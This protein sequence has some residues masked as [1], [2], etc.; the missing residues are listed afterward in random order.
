MIINSITESIWN[1]IKDYIGNGNDNRSNGENNNQTGSNGSDQPNPYED[2]DESAEAWL[3]QIRENTDGLEENSDAADENSDRLDQNSR[4][5]RALAVASKIA[6]AAV[7]AL[8][9]A[10]IS[11]VVTKVVEF[12]YDLA[13]QEEIIAEK[14][15][16]AKQNI[17]DLNKTFNE[18]KK[19]VDSIASSYEELSKGV[20]SLTNK[21]ISLSTEDYEKYLE[22]NNKLVEIFPQL[23]NGIDENG[24]VIIRFGD[25]SQSATQQ[26]KE[27][28]A[29]Q[30]EYNSLKVREELPDLT[31]GAAQN[32]DNLTEYEETLE[33]AEQ[34]FN[35]F[36]DV[37]NAAQ[38]NDLSLVDNGLT[39]LSED[40]NT[41]DREL[42][43]ILEKSYMDFYSDLSK[44]E[45]KALINL[46]NPIENEVILGTD[47]DGFIT[48]GKR[49]KSIEGLTKK[50]RDE[51][52]AIIEE[53]LSKE[54]FYELFSEVQNNYNDALIEFNSEDSQVTADFN[55]VKNSL[56]QG[57]E[58]YY[59]FENI[60]DSILKNS[61]RNMVS[62][63]SSDLLSDKDFKVD[64]IKWV[65]SNLIQPILSLPS[66]EERAKIINAYT[67]LI[68][69]DLD[70]SNMTVEEAQK[71]VDNLIQI[72]ASILN[73]DPVVIKAMFD[74]DES[75]ISEEL[76]KESDKVQAQAIENFSNIERRRSKNNK[77][78]TDF[79]YEI[80]KIKSN[81]SINS[82]KEILL[83]NKALEKA[84]NSQQDLNFAV[85]EYDKLVNETKNE[86]E[87]SEQFS[88]GAS[89]KDLDTMSSKFNQ[90]DASY[91]KLVDNDPNTN[92]NF[93][94]YKE[95]NDALTGV[96][97]LDEYLERLQK[98]KGNVEEVQKVFDDM[99]T[100][101]VEQMDLTH[102]LTEEN[103]SLTEEYLRQNGVANANAIVTANLE[104]NQIK[105]KL[106]LDETKL[107]SQEYISSISTQVGSLLELEGATNLT[108]VALYNMLGN[109][110][111][112]NNSNLD[113]SQKIQELEKLAL[114]FGIVA[115]SAFMANAN[116]EL[117]QAAIR[118]INTGDDSI[119]TNAQEKYY[120]NLRDE[121][122]RQIAAKFGE[123]SANYDGG[124]SSR[125]AAN[126]SGKEAAQEE[127]DWIERYL[128]ALQEKR[129]QL[130]EKANSSFLSYLGISED[131]LNRAKELLSTA[132]LPGSEELQELND[133]AQRAGVS[134]S[135]LQ[136][137]IFNG[138]G[139]GGRQS[140]LT[141]VVEAD[142]IL[143]KEN[144]KAAE[145]Y[146]NQYL[147]AVANI[148][149]DIRNKIESNVP[150]EELNVSEYPKEEADEINKVIDLHD[151]WKDKE[152]EVNDL[153]NQGIDDIIAK[154]DTEIDY[155]NAR[156]EAL[157]NSNSII[158]AEISYLKES[159]QLISS[160][161][162]VDLMNNTEGQIDLAE[163]SLK[164]RKEELKELLNDPDFNI[165]E[166]SETYYELSNEISSIESNIW[167]LKEAQEA[168]NNEL[169]QLPINN[170]D[171]LLNMYQS[172]TS[173]IESWGSVIEASGKKLD[174]TYYQTLINN[175]MDII[176]Q[177]KE[178]A[179]LVMEIMDEYEKGSDQWNDLYDKLTDISSE[180]NS[181]VENMYAWNEALLQLPLD[182]LSDYLNNLQQVSDS[183]SNVISEYDTVITAVTDLIN[184]EIDAINEEKDAVNEA[185]EDRIEALQDQLDLLDEQNEK[186]QLQLALEQ[187]Q[188][189]LEQLRNQKTNRVKNCPLL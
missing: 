136:N 57:L 169:I 111:I 164:T 28:I 124:V 178:Q 36:R 89:I 12:F 54:D 135:E 2:L 138:T 69:F 74:F 15:Q 162:Y 107:S 165:E 76:Q 131:D 146:K 123:L 80:D 78:T 43:R 72:I 64:P 112:F 134:V 153:R 104:A 188:Y 129:D 109:L 42:L 147:E 56:L 144:E 96:E 118:S 22:I 29:V 40:I 23:Y 77:S 108:S 156:N 159:G 25:K 126:S 50:Q 32:L 182:N 139:Y 113:T 90:L 120:Q 152:K 98:A 60:D 160:G 115:D 119:Y 121:Y 48:Y 181:I 66:S 39:F 11:F 95:I 180:I 185:Y 166:N 155:I 82:E 140:Y 161:M 145:K 10:L 49:L 88:F 174:Q 128:T 93:E 33:K 63:L 18:N 163:E 75:F 24:N 27:L 68:E 19:Y 101:L 179:D 171:I 99:A 127:I 52:S 9:S 177:Y 116:A 83:W 20:D 44:A 34:R 170:A 30:K 38:R 81:K 13:R 151:S 85:E 141:Q 173:E 117:S 130:S 102:N 37:L 41:Q 157:E 176:D 86:L 84:I 79:N 65:D 148:P 55:N 187:A 94:D 175:G 87:E 61:I 167:G 7:Q 125:D 92:I 132:I 26:L 100:A 105:E 149:E 58:S 5:N 114:S 150:I 62:N 46:A 97:N 143:L 16:E 183:I 8:G 4:A 35:R 53:N 133:I 142:R 91:S 184:E 189:D 47:E 3:D 168:Y 154:Y 103:A 1:R 21:N 158:E 51:L 70:T 137:M 71:Y 59:S 6:K 106:A 110:M 186:K 73:K 172:I 31:A 14:A 17:E 67:D 45:Q 122:E